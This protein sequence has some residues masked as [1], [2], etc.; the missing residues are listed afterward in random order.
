MVRRLLPILLALLAT[1]AAAKDELVLAMT[2]AP[3]TMNPIISSM[4]A[5]S[6]IQNMI[7]RPITAYDPEWKLVCLIGEAL[8]DLAK[9]T[10]RLVTL[11]DGKQGIET[12]YALKP[13]KWGDGTPVT[14][15]DIAFTIDVGKNPQSGVASSEGYRRIVRFDIKDDL[16]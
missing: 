15:R 1:P 5:K 8:P 7:A 9:G 13:M 6:L 3:G 12:D 14:A 16:H 2:Q 11:A 4:L 10:A